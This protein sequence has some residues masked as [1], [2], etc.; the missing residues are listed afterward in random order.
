[1]H[2]TTMSPMMN[3]QYIV[4][5]KTDKN[6]GSLKNLPKMSRFG[7]LANLNN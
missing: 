3:R 2:Y 5:I 1:M 7:Q 4:P 6:T